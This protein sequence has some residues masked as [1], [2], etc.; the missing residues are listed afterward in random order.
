MIEKALT[1]EAAELLPKFDKFGEFYL[2]G[3]TAL[4]LQIGHRISVDFDFFTSANLPSNLLRQVKMVFSDYPTSVT[5]QSPEQLNVLINN[6]KITFLYYEYGIIDDFTRFKNISLASVREIAA[7]KAL[8]IGRRLAYK[9]YVD[10]Y[11]LLKENHVNLKDIIVCAKKKF[12]GDF[13]DRLFLG[14]LV[15]VADIPSQKIDFLRDEVN[16][17]ALEEFFKETV[18]SFQF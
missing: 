2:A 6:I 12:D 16:R 8:A 18:R 15:S 13:N 1:E 4:A 9:D 10:W 5:Y 17:T 7:M 3:G 11:F 14:Q